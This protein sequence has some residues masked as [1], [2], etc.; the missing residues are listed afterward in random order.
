MYSTTICTIDPFL[1]DHTTPP[2]EN[3]PDLPA[4]RLNIVR[5][6][7][8]ASLDISFT[9]TTIEDIF[10]LKVPRLQITRG[11]EKANVPVC[12]SEPQERTEDEDRPK[13]ELR[14]EIKKWWE[15]VADHIDKIVRVF[16][17]L[18]QVD[19]LFRL[20]RRKS[21]NVKICFLSK[22]LYLGYHRLM[23]LTMYFIVPSLVLNLLYP[24]LPRSYLPHHHLLPT[25]RH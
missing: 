21:W 12:L 25:R 13:K 7:S 17:L 3:S 8:T 11:T 6:F 9:L 19:T 24:L 16:F 23:M 14:R 4:S 18:P 2:G 1:C 22:S 5:H 10:E 20:Y 15:G